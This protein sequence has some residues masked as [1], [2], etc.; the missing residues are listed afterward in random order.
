MELA[1][2]LD[3][4]ARGLRQAQRRIIE[5]ENSPDKHKRL[6]E[7]PIAETA[8][9]LG[10][11][12]AELRRLVKQ[13]EFPNGRMAGP[14]R[15]TFSFEDLSAARAWL[16]RD[17]TPGS[18]EWRRLA[19]GREG[20]EALQVV[21]FVNF[22][23]GSGKTT[24]SVL[25]AQ[26][27]ALRGYRILLVDLDAQASATASFG[28]SPA[29]EVP[30]AA[31]FAAWALRPTGMAGEEAAM[32]AAALP[33]ST[34]WSGVDLVPAGPSLHAAEYELVRRGVGGAAAGIS[35]ESLARDPGAELRKFLRAVAGRYDVI[36]CDTRPDV[37]MLMVNALRAATGLVVPVQANMVDLASSAE[38][39]A[40]LAA[41]L[42][43]TAVAQADAPSPFLRVLVTRFR[44]GDRSQ[45]AI[46]DAMQARFGD[47]VLPVVM[48]ET[49]MLGASALL[50][51][52]PYEYEPGDGRRAYDRAIEALDTVNRAI[53]LDLLRAWGRPEGTATAMGNAA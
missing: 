24:S 49:T 36:V 29:E 6:R 32:L 10:V 8:R 34:H 13:P 2:R 41:H 30:A 20:A 11:S 47:L 3:R 40:F 1:E 7:F 14:G 4:I 44:Q 28:V 5:S 27:L 38:F 45:T 18:V 22:K 48:L 52:T 46:L 37:N 51:E 23:G 17:A 50:K 35:A 43:E 21:S 26:Y 16:A 33:R 25:F 12:P 53:E 19:P 15:R 42:R 39:M 9:L 31:S